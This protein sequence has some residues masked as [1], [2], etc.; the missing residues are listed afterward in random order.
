MKRQNAQDPNK[1]KIMAKLLLTVL[2]R[3]ICAR[4]T[5]VFGATSCG[6]VQVAP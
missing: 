4:A 5:C 1:I 2:I 3:S 6:W